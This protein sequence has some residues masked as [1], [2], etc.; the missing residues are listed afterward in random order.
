MKILHLEG[1]I[2]KIKLKP[3]SHCS[4]LTHSECQ[5]ERLLT[6]YKIKIAE[7]YSDPSHD[8]CDKCRFV[9]LIVVV[10]GQTEG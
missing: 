8:Y 7:F 1:G 3:L 9:G 10:C 2:V 5:I 6:L 4:A